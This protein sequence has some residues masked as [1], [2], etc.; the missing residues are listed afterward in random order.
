[1]V[2]AIWSGLLVAAAETTFAAA[3]MRWEHFE[4]TLNNALNVR[5]LPALGEGS[6]QA[7][8]AGDFDE[9]GV[10]DLAVAVETADELVL[11]MYRGDS[12]AMYPNTIS[13]QRRRETGDGAGSPFLEP[14]L[15]RRT[16]ARVDILAAGDFDAD[17]HLDL[18]AAAIGDNLLRAY[19]GD[20][21][22]F[23]APA[24]PIALPGALTALTTGDFN[25]RDGLADVIAGVSTTQGPL[26]LIFEGPDGAL[27]APPETIALEGE[28]TQMVLGQLDAHFGID[29]AVLS[30]SGLSILHGR[31][32]SRSP[33]DVSVPR[34]SRVPVWFPVAAVAVGSFVNQTP[35]RNQ[36]AVVGQG[37]AV[38][39][40]T[41]S[42]SGLKL[43]GWEGDSAAGG[44]TL[45]DG[46][47]RW[48]VSGEIGHLPAAPRAGDRVVVLSARLSGGLTDDLV[49]VAAGD[50]RLHVM[51]AGTEGDSIS[52]K[53]RS[54]IKAPSSLPAVINGAVQS[55]KSRSGRVRAHSISPTLPHLSVAAVVTGAAIRHAIPMRLN[56]DAL[57]D[58][59]VLAA[60]SPQPAVISTKAG[61][62]VVVDSTTDVIDGMTDSISD[63]NA[64]RGADGVISLRE[65]ITAAN[66]TAG[67]DTINFNVPTD[68]D[69]GCDAGS[70]VCTIQPGGYGLPTVTEP[71]TIDATSQPGFSTTPL[72]EI[73]GSLTLTDATGFAINAGSTTIR[74]FV[75]NRF[76]TNSDIVMWGTGGNIIEGNFLGVDASGTTNLGATNSIHVYAI[77][78]NTIGG[79]T[80]AAR[81]LISG[82]TNPAI[83]LN[84][85]ASGN[86]VQGNFL[87]T[88]VTGMVALGN[89]GN[90]IVT[91]DSPNNTIGGTTVGA[92]NLV[93]GNLDPDYASIGL[94]FPGSSGNLVQGNLVGTDV[95]GTIDLGGA[96][97]GVYIAE[98]PNNTIGGTTAPAAN[99][100][101]GGGMS[102]VGIAIASGNFVQ[103][104]LIGTQVDGVTPLPNA[105]HGVL[106]YAG[107]ANNVVGGRSPGAENTIAFNGASGVELRGDAGTGNLI[108]GNSSF[109]NAAL[110]INNC[111]DY[112]E[113]S[114][115]CLDATAV[116]PNDSDD[117]DAGANNLQN[118][119]VVTGV[120]DATTVDGSLDSLASSDFTLDFYASSEC[121]PS[122]HGEGQTYL[123]SDTVTTDAGGDAVFSSTLAIAVPGGWYVTATATASDGSTSEFSQ[124]FA[125]STDL[126]F[127]DGFE[128]GDASA[129]STTVS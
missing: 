83:A 119:P 98:G 49:V 26:L 117:P 125:T 55:L 62:I 124:C 66:N 28:A 64:N 16:R 13:A 87:G 20:G 121:D 2:L 78:N 61:E 118:Y 68:T 75:I 21:L 30:R 88:D 108:V 102:G 51:A 93:A 100:I 74:G 1:M 111:A 85:G 73:D 86:L 123:G 44:D 71:A 126:I 67:A 5:D 56:S 113:G 116:T 92:R 29:L 107:A 18:L 104:N 31:D 106:L 69:P 15:V 43:A 91:L 72:I 45:S 12:H 23:F 99:L 97:I 96:S 54:E 37:G 90:D 60:G 89:S 34:V 9:D 33:G 7:L 57:H 3:P 17:G 101:S 32:L 105:S 63:L 59:V 94:G 36:L 24:R 25:R 52:V 10:P 95:S 80:A 27:S 103:G 50:D 6:A 46:L 128:S 4:F 53:A 47:D 70:G 14:E 22:G 112:D 129:W 8:A 115:T 19:R 48:W 120:S 65:A 11:V 82:N 110:G 35:A 39:L 41:H 122:G 114:L 127:T 79:T 76:V 58:L 38:R 81:N 40:V 77:S 42:T 109:G 84:A